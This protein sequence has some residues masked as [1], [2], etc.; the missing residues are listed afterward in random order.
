MPAESRPERV[1][2]NTVTWAGHA[3]A[4]LGLGVFLFVLLLL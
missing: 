1:V 2:H 4:A 3:R